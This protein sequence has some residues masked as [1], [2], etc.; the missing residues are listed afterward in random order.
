MLDI[1]IL[2]TKQDIATLSKFLKRLGVFTK[3]GIGLPRWKTLIIT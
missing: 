2:E 1:N 3:N